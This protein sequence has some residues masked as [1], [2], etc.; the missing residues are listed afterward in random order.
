M[1]QLELQLLE[2]RCKYAANCAPI[3]QF[4]KMFRRYFICLDE[5]Y[6]PK[7]ETIWRTI[8]MPNINWIERKEEVER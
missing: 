8:V 4:H 1:S 2:R 6:S 7:N 3:P 5:G